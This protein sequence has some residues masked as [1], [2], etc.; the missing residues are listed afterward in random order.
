MPRACSALTVVV[1]PSFVSIVQAH[2]QHDELASTS[3]ADPNDK[4]GGLSV[5]G[6]DDQAPGPLPKHELALGGDLHLDSGAKVSGLQW[7]ADNE[8]SSTTLVKAVLIVSI[9]AVF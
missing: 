8:G 7:L 3:E 5:D 1:P 2:S 4:R 6:R 9:P